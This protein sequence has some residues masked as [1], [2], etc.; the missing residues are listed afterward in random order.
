MPQGSNY[1]SESVRV[2]RPQ[3]VKHNSDT[4]KEG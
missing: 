3:H 4:I 1:Q 2:T